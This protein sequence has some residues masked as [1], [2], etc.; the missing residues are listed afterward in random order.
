MGKSYISHD[1]SKVSRSLS[2]AAL[3]EALR[4]NELPD[5]SAVA[6]FPKEKLKHVQTTEKNVIPDK[7]GTRCLSNLPI[8]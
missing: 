1:E 2:I 7:D 3:A 6:D 4:P 5:R 8:A